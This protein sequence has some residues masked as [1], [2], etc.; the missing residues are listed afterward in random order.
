MAPGI[1]GLPFELQL[2]DPRWL[3]VLLLLPLYAWQRWRL[4]RRDQL[5]YGALQLQAAGP[6]S[7]PPGPLW[8]MRHRG[9]P[10]LSL[11]V[12]VLLLA[13]LILGIAGP[14]RS[15]ELELMENEGIDVLLVLDVS[16]SMLAEDFPPN[17]M[18]ALRRIA[19]DFL[20]RASGHRIGLLI[21]G[22]DAYVQSPLTTDRPSLRA[23]LGGVTVHTISPSKS[24]GTAIGDAL[25]AGAQLLER[26]RRPQRDQ[27]LI[28]IT[29]GESNEG[30]EPELAARFV[31]HLQIRLYTIGLG[32]DEPMEVMFE[33]DKLGGEDDPYLTSLDEAQ[34]QR[35]AELADG[36][37]FR[38]TD[39]GALETIFGHLSRLES[40]P[41]EVTTV[42]IRRSY[43]RWLALAAL[44]L[45]TLYLLLTGIVLRRPLR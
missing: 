15:T 13:A 35:I 32:G 34:L 45:F 43:R 21:F 1:L 42:E 18:E 14:H 40:A 7:R 44:P 24:G 20:D 10:S 39:A 16:L 4:R 25:L 12:E 5:P 11:A 23:L 38:A 29:D 2:D 19:G 41:L 9:L 6:S 30:I 37:Y 36:H 26:A 3:W 31:H 22:K 28:L 8:L 27:A 17:R 33:G